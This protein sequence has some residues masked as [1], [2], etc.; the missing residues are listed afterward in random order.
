MAL[1]QATEK[2]LATL[3]HGN[4]PPLHQLDT[5]QARA[6]MAGVRHLL[7]PGPEL[8]QVCRHRLSVA[9]GQ[10]IELRAYRPCAQ[11]KG[12]MVFYHGGG[13]VLLDTQD[14]DSVL[15]LL[16]VESGY[17]VLSVDYRRAPEHPFPAPPD[18]AWQALL[19]AD[20]QRFELTGNHDAA[21]I[22]IGDS[23]GGNLAAVVAQRALRESR[24]HLAAQVLIYPVTQGD[25]SRPAYLQTSG[26]GLIG[27]QEMAWFWERYLPNP[28]QR[29]DPRAA[30]LLASSLSGLPPTVL[31]LAEHDVLHDE[32]ND[33]GTALQRAGVNVHTHSF[34]GQIHGFFG[35][36]GVLPAAG[37]AR[38][39]IVHCIEHLEL[40]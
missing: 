26:P 16:A 10:N 40:Q 38:R 28:A 36:P 2:L 15:R 5:Q 12:L 6:V 11:S 30:P 19:W 39:F 24:P 22:V 14:Y 18:D 3:T 29:L 17:T 23:A 4:P 25:L 8:F 33:Y 13:W 32:G 1:D 20:Q 27:P 34:A 9:P 31:L 7:E 37:E 21:L 35:F